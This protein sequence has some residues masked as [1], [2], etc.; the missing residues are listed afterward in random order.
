PIDFFKGNRSDQYDEG[1]NL[2]LF[3]NDNINDIFISKIIRRDNI[4]DCWQLF[5]LSSADS[6]LSPRNCSFFLSHKIVNKQ[7]LKDFDPYL[8]KERFKL[9]GKNRYLINF[10]SD[11]VFLLDLDKQ[12]AK[13]IFYPGDENLHMRVSKNSNAI[14]F[15][16]GLK[17]AF[18]LHKN[19][20]Y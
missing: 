12:E 20:F 5:K 17:K 15:I 11:C 18:L 1:E 7:S 2:I 9:Y 3:D 19:T 6:K 13:S 16:S 14:F 4:P 8:Y 10:N